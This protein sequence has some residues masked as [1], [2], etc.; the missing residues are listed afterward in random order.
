MNLSPGL[1]RLLLA[2]VVFLSHFSSLAIGAPAVASFFALSG[3]WI[4]GLWQQQPGEGLRRYGAFEGSR[5]L[6]LAPLLFI[7]IA[8]QVLI[9]SLFNMPSV[10]S[11]GAAWWVSQALIVGS[12]APGLVLP[13]Q[14]SLDVEMQFYL[15]APL[16]CMM[17]Q[18]L[19]RGLGWAVVVLLLAAG[20]WMFQAGAA[21]A[22]PALPPHLGFFLAGVM[23]RQHPSI[24]WEKTLRWSP[25]LV[26]AAFVV[27][28]ELRPLVS[29]LHV[30]AESAPEIVAH[31]A[32]LMVAIGL[33]CLPL[34]LSTVRRSSSKLDRF[35]GDLAY[36]LYLFHWWFRSIVYHTRPEDASASYKLFDTALAAACTLVVSVGL[37]LVVDRPIQRW[38][39]SQSRPSTDPVPLPA[40][41]AS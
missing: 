10:V 20:A 18:K 38:R 22:A 39:R 5:W 1:T 14:W 3:Y 25:L 8:G 21:L 24:P 16:L 32:L 9:H 13:P 26:V 31:Q 17:A 40:G 30:T 37:L 27:F 23:F 7:A 29:S 15:V 35:M 34:V 11:S 41:T 6:R 12:S 19:S 28:P 4:A 33:A 36:P 2:M